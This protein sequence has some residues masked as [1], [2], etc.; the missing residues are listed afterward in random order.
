M[1]L[2]VVSMSYFV[3]NDSE[4]R[5]TCQ[6]ESILCCKTISRSSYLQLSSVITADTELS[7]LSITQ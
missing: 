2:F 5:L 1:H 4:H 3:D 7:A 6:I